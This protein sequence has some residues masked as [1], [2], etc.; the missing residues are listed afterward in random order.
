MYVLCMYNVLYWR[1]VHIPNDTSVI[2]NVTQYLKSSIIIL[3]TIL[4]QDNK[5]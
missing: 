1:I 2:S 4:K 3:T 5:I